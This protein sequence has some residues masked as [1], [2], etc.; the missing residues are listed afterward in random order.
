MTDKKNR[1]RKIKRYYV[2]E[3]ISSNKQYDSS[4]NVIDLI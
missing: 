2:L 3:M 1:V 4:K